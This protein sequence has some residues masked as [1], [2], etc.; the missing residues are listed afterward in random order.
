MHAGKTQLTVAELVLGT[1]ASELLPQG[2]GAV[3]VLPGLSGLEGP[4]SDPRGRSPR[5]TWKPL[6]VPSWRAGA[7]P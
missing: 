5:W 2:G 6:P 1:Q 4:W 3:S 7:A